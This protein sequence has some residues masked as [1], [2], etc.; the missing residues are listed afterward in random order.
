[1][2]ATGL[3]PTNPNDQST[4]EVFQGP[5]TNPP[6]ILVDS[7]LAGGTSANIYSA[8][9]L[10]GTVGIYYVSFQLS[11]GQV[12]DPTTQLTIA[13]Q[14]HVSNVVYFPVAVPPTDTSTSTSSSTGSARPPRD[15][16]R[17]P[18]AVR[19]GRKAARTNRRTAGD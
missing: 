18:R 17:P 15:K 13:Q 10:P 12:T 4:G 11:T 9:L 8:A 14:A 2:Y 19:P 6:A 7:I 1:M 5:G 3:G 16:V